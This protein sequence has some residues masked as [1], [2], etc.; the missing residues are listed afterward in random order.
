MKSRSR[1]CYGHQPSR[2]RWATIRRSAAR[3]GRPPGA[4][5][6]LAERTHHTVSRLYKGGQRR[7]QGKLASPSVRHS[8]V[9]TRHADRDAQTPHAWAR[10]ASTASPVAGFRARAFAHPTESLRLGRQRLLLR[11]F[12]VQEIVLEGEI[13]EQAV[14]GRLAVREGDRGGGAEHDLEL[15]ELRK[16]QRVAEAR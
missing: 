2:L 12:L 8:A 16:V 1:S 3:H 15:V 9:P 11:F 6:F 7:G 14:V 5:P 10:H 13:E 4:G